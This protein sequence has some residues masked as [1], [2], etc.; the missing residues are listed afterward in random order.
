VAAHDGYTVSGPGVDVKYADAGP[1]LSRAVTA[2]SRADAP[3]S[4]Y[5]R[6]RLGAAVGRTDRDED[7]GVQVWRL[8]STKGAA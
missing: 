6:D 2:A 3:C 1:A 4:Y 8:N 7:G 5:V